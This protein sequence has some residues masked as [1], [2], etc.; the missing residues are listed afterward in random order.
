MDQVLAHRGFELMSSLSRMRPP[1]KQKGQLAMVEVV[2]ISAGFSPKL[3]LIPCRYCSWVWIRE[4]SKIICRAIDSAR[5]VSLP[6]KCVCRAGESAGQVSLPMTCQA[7]CIT[8][9]FEVTSVEDLPPCVL[10]FQLA[11]QV[12]SRQRY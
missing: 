10:H 1:N 12:L 3:P 8:Y 4:E 6:G 11:R 9:H 2:W 7:A 5:Q